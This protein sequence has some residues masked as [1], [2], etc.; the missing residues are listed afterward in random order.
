MLFH[1]DVISLGLLTLRTFRLDCN[2]LRRIYGAKREST[3]YGEIHNGFYADLDGELFFVRKSRDPRTSDCQS[4]GSQCWSRWGETTYVFITHPWAALCT[5][6]PNRRMYSCAHEQARQQVSRLWI[7]ICR[8]FS[9]TLM[10]RCKRLMCQGAVITPSESTWTISQ[11]STW[12]PCPD[13][14]FRIGRLSD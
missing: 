4:S 6:T 9:R 5:V 1:A 7:S 13:G 8:L 14:H 11:E 12:L 2:G 3:D 10:L